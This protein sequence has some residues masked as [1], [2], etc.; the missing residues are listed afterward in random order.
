MNCPTLLFLLSLYFILSEVPPLRFLLIL[1]L[2]F[3][4]LTVVMSSVMGHCS[5]TLFLLFLLYLIIAIFIRTNSLLVFFVMYELSLY[6]VCLLILLIGYQ[7]EK[8]KSML[9]L[10]L[11]T[12]VCSAPFLYF[13]LLTNLRLRSSLASS[14]ELAAS[15]ICLSF[16]VKS[17]LYTLHL[18]LPK[19]H[20]EADVT[21]SMLLA[22]VILKLGRYGLLILSPYLTGY[23]N[24]FI[25]LS[26]SGG[27][28]CSVICC[29]CSD[30]KSLVAYSSVVH[31]G[32]VSLGGLSGLELGWWVSCGIVVGHSLLSPLIFLLANELYQASGSRNFIYGHTSSVSYC[33]LF[34]ICLCSGLNFGLPP[35]LN[36]WVE[37]SLF[38]LQGSLWSLSLLPLALTAL[39]SFLYSILF[40]VLSCGGP[41][42][43]ALPV[44]FSPYAFIPSLAFSLLLTFGSSV[45][46]W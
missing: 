37:V 1:V 27:V 42:S 3:V 18:W 7:P 21:G 17:P 36:F 6:P 2:S 16:M 33:F 39:L 29:R 46:L 4:F 31:I 43:T 34:A 15:L 26:L 28:V 19:A 23:T 40:Y 20:V 35:F 41:C 12:V 32:T 8:I 11:Y 5:L 44:C 22:G 45:F 9:Y 10:L 24:I 38:S 30:M 13:T 14:T 25:Y